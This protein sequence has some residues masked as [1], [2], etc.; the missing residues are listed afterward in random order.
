MSKKLTYL[1]RTPATMPEGQ[2][3]IRRLE[4]ARENW[5]SRVGHF[6]YLRDSKWAKVEEVVFPGEY[7]ETYRST[8]RRISPSDYLTLVIQDWP[9]TKKHR[10]VRT[11]DL[12]YFGPNKPEHLNWETARKM[13]DKRKELEA[14]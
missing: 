8:F 9:N 6:V 5:A 14:L 13:R 11:K 2:N 4:E 7:P 12:K 3:T 10:W 1:P